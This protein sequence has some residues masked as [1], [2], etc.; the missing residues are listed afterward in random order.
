ME[1]SVVARSVARVLSI[2]LSFAMVCISVCAGEFVWVIIVQ[3]SGV[4]WG[5]VE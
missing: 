4:E 1:R 2:V 3:R 5:G